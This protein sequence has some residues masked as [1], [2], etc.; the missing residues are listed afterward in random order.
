MNAENAVAPSKDYSSIADEIEAAYWVPV[1]R[2]PF[3]GLDE[4]EKRS[5]HDCPELH[6]A[7]ASFNSNL[8][9]A[10]DLL[11]FPYFLLLPFLPEV[12]SQVE[13]A[14][15]GLHEVED[16]DFTEEQDAKAIEL[17]TVALKASKGL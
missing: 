8:H 7:F 10:K 17:V 11:E 2:T 1:I 6:Q 14:P 4:I 9:A 3:K 5:K 12:R 16:S 13:S 15:P